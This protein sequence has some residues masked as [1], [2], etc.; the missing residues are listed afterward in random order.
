MTVTGR[1][2]T[3]AFDAV[4]V[5]ALAA[6]YGELTGWKVARTDSD[7]I[8]L[9]AADGQELSFQQVEVHVPPQWPGQEH[10]QQ[11]HLDL[12]IDGHEAAAAR[13]VELGATRLADGATW[14]T[15]ADPAGHTFD[16]CQKD[17]VGPAMGL[18]E[19]AEAL[20]KELTEFIT[21]YV[22]HVRQLS[23]AAQV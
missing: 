14:I 4:D 10:P 2:E 9:Q 20:E 6:F 19:D 22:H 12:L 7:W 8:T 18:F 21:A 11:F 13:A 16:L 5:D 3:V 23:A 1:L 17:G 15:M